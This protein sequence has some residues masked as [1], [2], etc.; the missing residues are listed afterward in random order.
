MTSNVGAP[1]IYKARQC[2][3]SARLLLEMNS[4]NAAGDRAFF[5]AFNAMR[6]V[7]SERVGL[8][9]QGVKTH[10]GLEYLFHLH[11]VKQGLVDPAFTKTIAEARQIRS[12]ADFGS[13]VVPRERVENIL[14]KVTAL[15]DACTHLTSEGIVEARS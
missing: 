1:Y 11:V 4:T 9:V 6:A 3:D 2:L 10:S 12:L 13:T 14:P 5:G 8:D 15:V 7:L